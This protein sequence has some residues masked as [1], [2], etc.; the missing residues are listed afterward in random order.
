[1]GRARGIQRRDSC[2]CISGEA[3]QGEVGGGSK[4]TALEHREHSGQRHG[5]KEAKQYGQRG[6][7]QWKMNVVR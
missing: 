7:N 1:M 3:C 5:M 6:L 4:D 2:R